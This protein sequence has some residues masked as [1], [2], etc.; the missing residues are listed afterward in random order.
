[1]ADEIAQLLPGD[2]PGTISASY[3]PDFVPRYDAQGNVFLIPIP[4]DEDG[5]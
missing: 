2:A 3:D 4:D 1:M 5:S